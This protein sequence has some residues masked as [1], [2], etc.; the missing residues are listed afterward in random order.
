VKSRRTNRG[1]VLLAAVVGALS[2]TATASTAIYK[3]G[4]PAAH[5]GSASSPGIVDPGRCTKTWDGPASGNWSAA[6]NWTGDAAPTA[7]DHV[8]IGD[9]TTVTLN[10]IATV[11]TVQTDGSLIVSGGTLTLDEADAGTPSVA[12]SLTQQSNGTVTGAGTLL[13]SSAL[14]WHGGAQ[15]GTGTTIIGP[16]ATLTRP[17]ANAASLIQRTLRVEGTLIVT[18]SASPPQ[19]SNG[20]RIEVTPAGTIDFQANV[21][22]GGDASSSVLNQG[23]IRKSGGAS[24]SSGGVSLRLDNQGRLLAEAGRMLGGVPTVNYSPSE[25]KLTGGTYDVKATLHLSDN[26]EIKTN[27]AHV[28]LDG[29][30]SA[31]LVNGSPPLDA[32]RSFQANAVGSSMT[33]KNGRTLTAP[34]AFSNAGLISVDG[35]STFASGPLANTATGRIHGTGTVQAQLTSNGVVAPGF[36]T[37]NPPA[38]LL[39]LTGAYTAGP[40]GKLAVDIGGLTPGTQHDQLQVSGAITLGGTLDIT[41]LPGFTPTVGQSFTIATGS[42][43]TGDFAAIDGADLPGDLHYVVEKTPT[44]AILRVLAD[45]TVSVKDPSTAVPEGGNAIFLLQLSSASSEDV[46]VSYETQ[47]GTAT[48]PGDYTPVSGGTV[49]FDHDTGQVTAFVTIPTVEDALDEDD[50]TVKLL[51][52]GATGA[53]LGDSVAEHVITDDDPLP[54]L[55][56]TGPDPVVEGDFGP[57][58]AGFTVSLS[59]PSGREVSV[60][61]TTADLEA[62][63][64][65]DYQAKSGTLTF[66]AGETQKPIDVQV[67]GDTIDEE[68]EVFKL[69]LSAP[70]NAA[71]PFNSE[72]ATILDDD[73]Q[74][75]P[76]PNLTI[77]GAAAD[78]PKAQPGEHVELEWGTSN[79]GPGSATAPWNDA[80]Y[81]SADG[82]LDGSDHLLDSVGHL[83][84]LLPG[85]QYAAGGAGDVPDVPAGDYSL[86]IRTDDGLGL[87]ESNEN[88]NVFVLPFTVTSPTAPCIAGPP[89]AGTTPTG[90]QT[91]KLADDFA[92]SNSNPAPDSHGNTGIWHFCTSAGLAHEE[93]G[94]TKLPLF[95]PDILG[96]GLKGW[97]GD[98]TGCG[99]SPALPIILVNPGSDLSLCAVTFAGHAVAVHPTPAR[100]AIVAWRSP[101]SGPIR[102]AGGVADIDAGGGDGVQWLVAK[103]SSSV[104]SGSIANGGAQEFPAGLTVPVAVGDVLYFGVHPG[105]G[106]DYDSTELDVTLTL[107]EPDDEEPNLALIAAESDSA[108]AAPGDPVAVSWTTRNTGTATATAPWADAVYISTDA[109]LEPS[110]DQRLATLGHGS[111]LSV[112]GQYTAGSN[113]AVPTLPAGDYFLLVRTDDG[114]AEAESNEA[115]NVFVL[116]FT[117]TEAGPCAPTIRTLSNGDPRT[118]DGALWIPVDGLGAV[119]DDNVGTAL[120]NPPGGLDAKATLFYG[121]L[122]ASNKDAFLADCAAATSTVV[123]QSASS[124]VTSAQVGALGLVLNQSV[125]APAPDGSSQLTQRYAFTNPGGAPQALVLAHVFD[126]DLSFL[127]SRFADGMVA[128]PDGSKLKI[129]DTADPTIDNP[130]VEASGDLD[131]GDG[132][133]EAFTGQPFDYRT[134]VVQQNGIRPDDDG[135]VFGDDDGDG[136]ADSMHDFNGTRESRLTLAPG[137]TRT[138]TLVTRF[139]LE[140]ANHA[141]HADDDSFALDQDGSLIVHP[142]GALGND[143]DADGDELIAVLVEGPAH[144]TLTLKP[145]GSFTYVPD[146][147]FNGSDTF[148]YKANDGQADSNLAVVTLRVKPLLEVVGLTKLEG[149]GG[150]TP[151]GFAVRLT[152]PTSEP[153]TVELATVVGT[154][155]A[156]DFQPR[157]GTL[158]FTPGGALEQ[159]VTVQVVADALDE[160]DEQFLLRLA[161]PQGARIRLGHGEVA[162]VVVDDDAP[163][164]LEIGDVTVG[165]GNAGLTAAT[166]KLALSGPSGKPVTVPWSTADVTATA[167]SDYQ[168]ASGTVTFAPGETLK[169]LTVNVLGDT[170]VEPDETFL[171]D[172]GAIQNVT[173]ADDGQGI[174]TIRND[175]T[176][177]VVPPPPAPANCEHPS[178]IRGTEGAD[179][180]T[181]TPSDDIICAG[182]GVDVVRGLGGNDLIFGGAGEDRLFG[183]DGNDTVRGEAG[184]DSIDGESGNDLLDGGIGDDRIKSG[185]GDD[186]VAGGAGRDIADFADAP[187]PINVDLAAGAAGGEGSDTISQIE[188]VEGSAHADR[189][190]GD[191]LVNG[192][193]GGRGADEING[194]GGNDTI[195]GQGGDDEL[196][197]GTGRD[198][199]LIGSEGSD[200][201]QLAPGGGVTILCERGPGALTGRAAAGPVSFGST[202][203]TPGQTRSK[204][205]TV[206][207]SSTALQV[208]ATWESPAAAFDVTVELVDAKGNVVGRGLASSAK[209]RAR[210]PARLALKTSRGPSYLIVEAQTP[211]RLRVG[212]KPLRLRIKLRTKTIAGRTAVSTT[213]VQKRPR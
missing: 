10:T 12:E 139:G 50:E 140:R 201:C 108:S 72:F 155:T 146:A 162:G 91:W 183:G 207:P 120:Y 180:L 142:R 188:I 99:D 100:M 197:A 174:G 179:I 166:F 182:G 141:P 40:A 70:A 32:F 111:D 92:A 43:V 22:L 184:F 156:A 206:A 145:D 30:A 65:G 203:A 11:R 80:V 186:Q 135:V 125:G 2:L 61:Y 96:S 191:E 48:A 128:T 107:G 104:A 52:S 54:E 196:Q 25:F 6:G 169:S 130:Y 21:T 198:N 159:T 199:N 172:L 26:T 58:N 34:G 41:T 133:P 136:R 69:V 173:V 83:S 211:A 90:V 77:T 168:A 178:T 28:I 165:E 55:T 210:K 105:G 167:G 67:N 24:T 45:V 123:S 85:A 131:G 59:A 82:T 1:T 208:V 158:S 154:A 110:A 18:A 3:L 103:G 94:L 195:F 5:P 86:I 132:A 15:S 42:S 4:F 187:G 75:A 49:T 200:F 164:V 175:D 39:K 64:P 122:Y 148:V 126:G 89:P 23:T 209:P 129:L 189:L 213:I 7:S 112:G 114:L 73:D 152:G 119:G 20:A 47:D 212:K 71:L 60:A 19:L 74:P 185:A 117:V 176:A 116:P 56:I 66:A 118:T 88:D 143:D 161:N 121:G 38:G 170:A 51:L 63:A 160:L 68:D 151:F 106:D 95:N 35:T 46:T 93:S 163:P 177:V 13:V 37:D 109:T 98:F 9:G 127:N 36:P 192:F 204:T 137:E 193:Y 97:H 53:E 17:A 115:D 31:I 102:I 202:F 147:G 27:A 124:L 171:V 181:G 194:R 149:T 79:T 33:L 16:A 153:V 44:A 87:A 113:V 205:V 78:R 150:L 57:A 8:C 101:V 29:P 84:D 144:G 14:L 76:R 81:L 134:V 190:L 62:T 157:S 138:L